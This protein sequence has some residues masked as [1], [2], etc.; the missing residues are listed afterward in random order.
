MESLKQE[1]KLL[2]ESVQKM[3]LT[4]DTLVA[5]V[6]DFQGHCDDAIIR[7]IQVKKVPFSFY[8]I[9]KYRFSGYIY[10]PVKINIFSPC[11]KL[12]EFYIFL[13]NFG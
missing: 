8:E 1:A 6:G 3:Q 13:F 7:P 12:I 5:A 10:G 2:M 9:L 11:F 4:S